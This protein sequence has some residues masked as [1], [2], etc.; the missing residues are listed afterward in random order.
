MEPMDEK[1]PENKH[2]YIRYFVHKCRNKCKIK[3]EIK[4]K[5]G[6]TI[7]QEGICSLQV[8]LNISPG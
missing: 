5:Y 3:V 8:I 1:L 4:L 7:L 2:E 6:S